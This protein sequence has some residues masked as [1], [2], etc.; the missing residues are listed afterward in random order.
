MK[1]G[2]V[3][4]MQPYI[5]PYIGYFHLI[6][7]SS[8]F[9]VYDD[10][11]YI[12]RGWINRNRILNNDQAYL[13]TVPVSKASQNRLIYET[14]LAIDSKWQDKFYKRLTYSYRR[15]PF[16]PDV[17]ELIYSVFGKAC[18][19]VSDLAIE[20]ILAVYEYL[21]IPVNLTKSS[22]CSPNSK[23]I[24]RADRL[25]QITKSLEYDAYVNSP[26]GK[27]LYMKDYFFSKGVMLAFVKSK[28]IEY[29]QYSERF[30]PWL[31]IIDVLMF[32]DRKRV[33]DFF[34][35]YLLE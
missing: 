23:G 16:F 30:V 15:A 29:K 25:I 13:F 14:P 1:D 17:L 3:A 28:P 11:H 21:G 35:E 20:S 9:V 33:K 34:A 5:F 6:E 8:I 27:Q 19:A 31:S 18:T 24:G 4:I 22:I 7:A 2:Y 26:G 10:V 12:R 32:N